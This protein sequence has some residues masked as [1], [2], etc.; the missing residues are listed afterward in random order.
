MNNASALR[1]TVAMLLA[2]TIPALLVA[3]ISREW[4][5]FIP[6]SAVALAH[7]IV[8]GVPA[9]T[10]LRWRRWANVFTSTASGALV[11]AIPVGVLLW[12]GGDRWA[13]SSASVGGVPT[14]VDGVVTRAGWENY[15]QGI[16]VFALFGAAS[17]FIFW[18]LL[19]WR[20]GE[21]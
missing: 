8:L 18:L 14:M 20:A 1:S 19:R 3:L 16:G 6:I 13:G 2:S 15:F 10:L 12:P 17:G 11:G 21:A 9:Y 5:V 4:A 7:A